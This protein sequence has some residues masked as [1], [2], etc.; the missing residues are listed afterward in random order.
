MISNMSNNLLWFVWLL[1]E[2]NV[3][4]CELHMDST[5]QLCKQI[6]AKMLSLKTLTDDVF[7][8]LKARRSNNGSGYT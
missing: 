4:V 8:V 3:L 7:K 5:C 6:L 1:K 2:L